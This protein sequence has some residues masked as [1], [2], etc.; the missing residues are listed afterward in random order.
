MSDLTYKWL[1]INAL[2]Q[3]AKID[4]TEAI[5]AVYEQSGVHLSQKQVEP[6]VG[7][8]PSIPDAIEFCRD[9]MQN[10]AVTLGAFDVATLVGIGIMTPNVQSQV[11]QLAFL[12]I[13]AEH[14]RRG[15]AAH[16]LSELKQRVMQSGHQFIYVTA[17]PTKSAVGFYLRA[18]F[19]PTDQPIPHL[20]ALEP[21]DIHMIATL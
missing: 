9:H 14:R 10:G 13:S 21:E 7:Q 6:F 5:D 3:I 2:D 8:W 1:D 18:G 16:L 19:L 4:R 15:I 11:A 20:L 12:H 17:T